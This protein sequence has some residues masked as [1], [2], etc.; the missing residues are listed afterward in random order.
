MNRGINES[1]TI[2]QEV[3]EAI[4]HNNGVRAFISAILLAFISGVFICVVNVCKIYSAKSTGLTIFLGISAGILGI[5]AVTGFLLVRNKEKDK[6]IIYYRSVYVLTGLLLLIW[7][8]IDMS[9]S[10][11]MLLL[12]ISGGF[13]SLV[14]VLSGH[15]R[16]IYLIGY[17]LG[18]IITVF[19]SNM[20]VR[21]VIEGIIVAAGM[22]L[23]GNIFQENAISYERMSYK[24]K[25]KTIS[26]ES[27]PLTG[28]NNR[29]G[30][31]RKASVLW[32]YCMENSMEIGL[33]E[34][35]VDFFKKYN[36]KF[37]HPAGDKCLKMIA[38]AIK[39]AAYSSRS[40]TARTGGEEFVVFV[41]GLNE[42]EL[43]NL[44]LNIRTTVDELKIA[45]AYAGVS[46]YV[47]VSM[48][49]SIITPD[50]DNSFQDLYEAADKALYSA[51]SN[52]RHCI[53]CGNR[54][55]GRMR[56]GIASVISS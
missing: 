7:S 39:E 55:Y 40:I 27:D 51:K 42:E 14:P 21:N 9:I 16:R 12:F 5:L 35:D 38:D 33:I 45:H 56:K 53:V 36:D 17:F 54:M 22:F 37:G 49:V 44:A 30:L 47:T 19:I 18:I 28:L 48:G 25:A 32:P 26:S 20:G 31:S 41:Q 4:N 1:R 46:Q 6:I 11:S 2:K 8:G 24:L 23:V 29:R 10:G 13:M 50:M 34:I 52:G 15:E 43:V 3:V